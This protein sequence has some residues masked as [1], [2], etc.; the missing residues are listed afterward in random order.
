MR[1]SRRHGLIC[2]FPATDQVFG[3]PGLTIV[4]G[5]RC[6]YPEHPHKPVLAGRRNHVIAS[7]VA[8]RPG[9]V[10]HEVFVWDLD[11][12]VEFAGSCRSTERT[13]D[14]VA[15]P[16]YLDAQHPRDHEAQGV[17]RHAG[18][19]GSVA[20]L[21]VRVEA[22]LEAGLLSPVRLRAGLEIVHLAVL[23]QHLGLL[24][25][26]HGQVA[27][28]GKQRKPCASRDLVVLDGKGP[29][30]VSA[31]SYFGYGPP[32]AGSRTKASS[33]GRRGVFGP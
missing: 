29:E 25:F 22:D 19:Q 5:I 11:G 24:A 6:V 23:A 2:R 14:G 16:E 12:K 18:A 28:G 32:V 15:G 33:G 3:G 8:R 13:S 7:V 17:L 10:A 4:V 9:D 21:G 30:G 20:W 26:V 31:G 27:V 1:I